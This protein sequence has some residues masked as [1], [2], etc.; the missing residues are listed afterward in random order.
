MYRS[1]TGGG[2]K[3]DITI[4]VVPKWTGTEVDHP[5]SRT[6]LVPNVTYP[7]AVNGLWLARR[8]SGAA[9]CPKLENAITSYFPLKQKNGDQ[10]TVNGNMLG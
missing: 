6:R 7:V 8:V 3:R 5:W 1:G 2:P 10:C 9:I 4:C